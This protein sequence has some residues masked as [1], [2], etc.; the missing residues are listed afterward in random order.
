[1]SAISFQLLVLLI[2]LIFILVAISIGQTPDKYFK[3]RTFITYF[4]TFQ[5][6]GCSLLA[7]QTFKLRKINL[8]TKSYILWAIFAF[9]FFYLAID[10]VIQ[11][12][13]NL[14][15]GIHKLFH[16]KM[17]NITDRLDDCIVALYLIGGFVILYFF[18]SEIK[19]YPGLLNYLIV[20]FIF[21]F[22]MVSLDFITERKDV[23]RFLIANHDIRKVVYVWLRTIEEIFK[24][25]AGGILLGMFY[26]VKLLTNRLMAMEREVDKSQKEVS[27]GYKNRY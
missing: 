18:R 17:T 9:C 24:L 19:I 12:H 15:R 16:M 8:Q 20:G 4:S 11:I 5:L 7:W 10:E 6:L 2:D 23:V 26:H 22:S 21:A 3:E 13:E 27:V 25:F 1:M 14:D